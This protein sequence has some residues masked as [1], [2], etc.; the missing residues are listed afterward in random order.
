[1]TAI[2]WDGRE[3]SA[4]TTIDQD[5]LRQANSA[6]RGHAQ[7]GIDITPSQARQIVAFEMG[8]S[9]AQSLD[10]RAGNL[11]AEAA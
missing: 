10:N 11:Q 5:L 6:T 8:L 7:A 4:T 1:M 9:T 3:S 2:M